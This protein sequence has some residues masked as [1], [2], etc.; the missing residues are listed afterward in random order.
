MTPNT[1]QLYPF[2]Q[3][4]AISDI[5]IYL[6]ENF[7]CKSNVPKIKYLYSGVLLLRY[8]RSCNI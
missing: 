2:D 7:L 1:I 3:S 4:R 6:D 5:Q 8:R